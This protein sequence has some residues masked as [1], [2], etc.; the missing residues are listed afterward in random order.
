MAVDQATYAFGNALAVQ[1]QRLR[2]LEAL[3]DEGT[4]RLLSA[5]GV[6]PGSRC[7]EVGAGGGS[8]AWFEKDGLLK[9]GPVSAGAV[10]GPACY[11]RGGQSATVTDANMVL[12][13]LSTR[14]LLGGAIGLDFDA[15]RRVVQPIADR[16]GFD[17]GYGWSVPVEPSCALLRRP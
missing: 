8:I 10:P 13:R 6:E 1:R 9:V 2:S 5:R 17:D 15:S 4:I 11:G 12:G 3:L 7:L 14:G 16:L